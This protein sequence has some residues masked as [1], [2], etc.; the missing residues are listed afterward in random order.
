MEEEPKNTETQAESPAEASTQET[1]PVAAAS[2]YK[3]GFAK[4]LDGFFGISKAGS[5]I[6]TEIIAGI[7]T[8][9]AMAYILIIRTPT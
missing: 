6:Y 3:N 7:V 8:F 9:M 5:R 1:A 2:P 4:R